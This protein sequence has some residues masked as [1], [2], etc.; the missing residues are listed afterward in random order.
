MMVDLSL[1][2]D[3][4][5]ILA[6]TLVENLRQKSVLLPAI[7]AIDSICAEAI[8]S[9]NRI[10]YTALTS[11]LSETHRQNIDALL[12]RK[13]GSK[14]TILGWLRQSPAKPNSKY[15]LEHIER[16]KCLQA[17]DLPEDIGKHVHQNRLLKIAREG[18]QMT[19]AD[20]ARF[21]SQRRYATLVAIV[22][23]SMAT[24]TD[25]II[26]LHDRIIGKL[27]AIAKINT[28]NNFNHQVKRSTTKCV[29]MGLSGKPC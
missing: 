17:I 10:I 4:G 8:T 27:F 26:D 20:L 21:E 24:I 11:S 25:E 16:L 22:V 19:P 2:T 9:A 13:E 15:M 12:N 28:S 3:K 6:T 18:G 1:Q 14:L 29:C 7:N 23:E 5:L